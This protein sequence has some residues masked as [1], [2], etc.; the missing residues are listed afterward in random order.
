MSALRGVFVKALCVW[1]AII[2]LAIL[3]GLVRQEVL[4]PA[5]GPV[6]GLAASGVL[7]SILIF[8]AAWLAAPWYGAAARRFGTWIGVFW[9]VLTLGF[10]IGMAAGA[11]DKSWHDV[12][13]AF[14][15]TT[16]NLWLL[17]LATTLF[18][19]AIAARRSD[20]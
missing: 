7:L 3:N 5:W 10:E 12:A 18:A 16:G 8:I 14:D 17:V 2:P 20:R 1:A 15:P 11:Q 13:R 19:P 9:L 6:A 4:V